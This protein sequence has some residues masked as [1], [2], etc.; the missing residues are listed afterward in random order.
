[1]API[2]GP[3]STCVWAPAP[4]VAGA[5]TQVDSGCMSGLAQDSSEGSTRGSS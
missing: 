2:G 3:L 1:M 5:H 4:A